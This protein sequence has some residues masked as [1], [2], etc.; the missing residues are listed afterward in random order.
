MEVDKGSTET[1]PLR[2]SFYPITLHPPAARHA[3]LGK[4]SHTSRHDNMSPVYRG[5]AAVPGSPQ[6]QR[7]LAAVCLS[8][9]DSLWVFVCFCHVACLFALYLCTSLSL[10]LSLVTSLCVSLHL[11]LCLSVSIFLSVFL[12]E[13]LCLSFSLPVPASC[14]LFQSLLESPCWSRVS[15][16]A[17]CSLDDPS[18]SPSSVPRWKFL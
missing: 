10:P 4:F 2:E 9:S 12:S 11:S 13:F 17:P 14:L 1:L 18:V 16:G 6:S 3:T 8:P 15:V 5:G 7:G